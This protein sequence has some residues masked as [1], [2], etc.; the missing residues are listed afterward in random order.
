[1]PADTLQIREG[2]E[3]FGS[4]E[5]CI[6]ETEVP[7]R[8][9]EEGGDMAVS[10]MKHVSGLSS[11]SAARHQARSHLVRRHGPP[12]PQGMDGMDVMNG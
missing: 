8:S 1:M 7:V 4:E 10:L 2:M 9:I 11:G 6:R 5:T 3:S 12:R